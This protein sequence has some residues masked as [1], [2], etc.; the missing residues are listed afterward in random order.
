MATPWGDKK[1][2]PGKATHAVS[3]ASGTHTYTDE[4]KFAFADWINDALRKDP[5]LKHLLPLNVHDDSLFKSVHDGILMC[6]LINDAVPGTVDERAINKTKLNAFRIGEN[7]TLVLNSS[8]SIGCNVINISSVDLMDGINHLVLGLIWQIIRIGLLSKINLKNH[9]ELYRLLEPGETIEDLLRLPADQLLLR[10]V[11]Y[12]LRE[13]G[14]SRRIRNFGGDIADSEAYTILLKQIAPKNSGVDT[15]AMNESD[16]TKRAQ[17]MLEQADKIDC[18]KF[19]RPADVVNGNTKLNLAFVAN[20]FNH[21]PA[22]EPVEEVVEEI[23]EETREEKTYRNWMNSLGVDPFVNHL[24]EDLRDGIVLLQLLDKIQPGIVDWKKVNQPP[25]KAMGGNMKKIENCNYAI[26]IAASLKFSL[27][28]IEGKDIF[29]GSKTHTLAVVWQAMRAY[30]LAILTKLSGT[31]KPISDN[32]IIA[33][34]NSV[35]PAQFKISGWKD[36]KIRDS[37]PTA[38]IVD[39]IRAGTIEHSNLVV[40]GSEEDNVN[41]AKYTISSARKIGAVVYTLPEDVA[42]GNAKMILTMFAALMAASL[43]K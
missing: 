40:G 31:G 10:W 28:G 39:H 38:H 5:D 24:Y 42:E 26:T 15:T 18:K 19:V 33:W 4:E 30:T 35:L 43:Q 3:T 11:N 21:Y 25:F 17:K 34:A 9:P 37:R 23:I 20:L 41:N 7:Q 14:S 32:E 12:H 2:A 22:L 8:R 27:V 1:S 13:A 16:R 36:D 6:K 29:D